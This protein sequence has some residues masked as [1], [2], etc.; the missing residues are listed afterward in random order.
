MKYVLPLLLLIAFNGFSQAPVIDGVFTA[1]EWQQATKVNIIQPGN[2]TTSVYILY[3]ANYM[4]FAFAGHLESNAMF[5]EILIDPAF[6]RG[7]SWQ[8]DD[9]WFH[10]SA[11][12]CEGKGAYG[13]Y[14][15]CA[16]V[17]ANWDAA[18]N[19]SPGAP[20]TDTMEVRI[21]FTKIGITPVTGDTIGIAFVL[22][23]TVNQ[24]YM[25]PTSADRMKPSTWI[26]IIF[27]GGAGIEEAG[28]ESKIDVVITGTNIEI[29]GPQ[30]AKHYDV[31]IFDLNGR[32]I[33]R[34][35]AA[36]PAS[37]SL[38]QLPSGIYFVQV[39]SGSERVVR[40]FLR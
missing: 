19:V 21:S 26:P 9:W 30:D 39:E 8:S 40:K 14:D 28:V 15:T 7:T 25:Y 31:T 16:T 18:P 12:D 11:T 35:S 22:T 29:S 10:V 37:V 23:N 3:D 2:E 5:P 6:N 13:G 4:Y 33:N 20:A 17:L 32:M 34:S 1:A 24:W 27:Q 36:A 38:P